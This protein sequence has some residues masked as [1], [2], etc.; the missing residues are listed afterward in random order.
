VELCF[1]TVLLFSKE[2]LPGLEGACLSEIKVII[3]SDCPS[4]EDLDKMMRR[5]TDRTGSMGQQ[6]LFF[7]SLL[8]DCEGTLH[9]RTYACALSAEPIQVYRLQSLLDDVETAK[10]HGRDRARGASGSMA[11]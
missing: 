4:I 2:I 9:A 6:R 8:A 10:Q 1:L 3:E 7:F 11:P 5:V